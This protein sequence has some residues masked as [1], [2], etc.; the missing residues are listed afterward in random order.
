MSAETRKWIYRIAVAIFAVL[1]YYGYVTD[2]EVATWLFLLTAILGIGT[3]TLAVKN[4]PGKDVSVA[5]DP[6]IGWEKEL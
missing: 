3:G 4:V 1:V 5:E 2:A 6:S